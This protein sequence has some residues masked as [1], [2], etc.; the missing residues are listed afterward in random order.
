MRKD[1]LT[2]RIFV[3]IIVTIAIALATVTFDHNTSK[4]IALGLWLVFMIII[5]TR[6]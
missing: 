2:L 4:I 1:E 5:L 3:A 6:D